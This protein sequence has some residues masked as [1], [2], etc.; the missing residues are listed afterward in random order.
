MNILDTIIKENKKKKR[1]ILNRCPVCGEL[2]ELREQ[3]NGIILYC[4]KCKCN[5]GK[6]GSKS[7][8]RKVKKLNG[9]ISAPVKAHTLNELKSMPYKQYLQSSH[10]KHRRLE[11]YKTH[12]KIC[13]CCKNESY[14]LHHTCYDRRGE[15]KDEDLIPLCEDCHNKIHNSLLK[16][17]DISLKNAH[18]VLIDL[19]KLGEFIPIDKNFNN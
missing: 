10:W 7:W 16:E 13:Y 2:L 8:G 5:K 6:W 12:K 14:V 3:K 11:Y 1:R 9:E 17:K 19:I 15:E 4:L 18:N